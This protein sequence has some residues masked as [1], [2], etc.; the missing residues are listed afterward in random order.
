MI[1]WATAAEKG[2]GWNLEDATLTQ[3][4]ADRIRD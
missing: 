2:A 3:G 1:F 4:I